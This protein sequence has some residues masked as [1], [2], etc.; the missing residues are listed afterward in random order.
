MIL[1]GHTVLVDD[2]DQALAAGF[3]WYVVRDGHQL[4]AYANVKVDG[5]PTTLKMHRLLLAAPP[6][7]S[8]D[9]RNRNGLDNRRENLR[10]A[11][12][13]E[14]QHNQASRPGTSRFKGVY[15]YGSRWRAMIRLPNGRRK[16][17]GYFDE[18]ADA[19]HA[20]DKAASEIHGDFE[21]LNFPDDDNGPHPEG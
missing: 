14:Q 9:H 1:G 5:R 8:V 20:Y 16:S 13:R 21:R 7:T 3:S 12:A 10:L 11:T 18:E 6:G 17:L 2:P 15:A 19:A 4:Y